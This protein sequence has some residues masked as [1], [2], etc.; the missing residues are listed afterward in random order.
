MRIVTSEK[1]TFEQ[2]PL[3]INGLGDGL[4]AKWIDPETGT[5]NVVVEGAPSI[6]GKVKLEDIQAFVDSSQLTPGIHEVEVHWNLPLYLKTPEGPTVV[7]VQI[8]EKDTT[9]TD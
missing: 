9:G 5:L 4:E 2:I 3:Q 8:F 1:R 7:R 6:L